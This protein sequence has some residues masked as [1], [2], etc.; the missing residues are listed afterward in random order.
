MFAHINPGEPVA[1]RTFDLLATL[2]TPRLLDVRVSSTGQ[3][4]LSDVTQLF[5]GEELCAAV[6]LAKDDPWPEKV[7]ITG[8]IDVLV[9]PL[10]SLFDEVVAGHMHSRDGVWTGYLATPPLV[11]EARAA[12]LS[13]YADDHG[14]DLPRSYAYGDSHGDTGLNSAWLSY[15]EVRA[16]VGVEWKINSSISFTA[17]AGYVPWRQFDYF[18]TEVRYHNESGAPYGALML[19]GAF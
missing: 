19:H 2:D 9:E 6:R 4:F 3:R 8:T 18:R 1:W 16:G 5:Q 13:R 12:W 14:V 15:T 10:A 11:D 7:F 17:E